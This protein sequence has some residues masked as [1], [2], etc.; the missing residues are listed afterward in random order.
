MAW[1]KRSEVFELSLRAR[2]EYALILEEYFR[3]FSA[4]LK[5]DRRSFKKHFANAERLRK[6]LETSADFDVVE[7]EDDDTSNQ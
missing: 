6:E 7:M 1:E 4:I 3:T 2:G 5:R